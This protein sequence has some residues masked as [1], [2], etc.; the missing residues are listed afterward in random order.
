MA[1]PLQAWPYSFASCFTPSRRDS[2][3]CVSS[4]NV[5]GANYRKPVCMCAPYLYFVS[6]G[7]GT[8]RCNFSQ[9]CEQLQS[10]YP[11]IPYCKGKGLLKNSDMNVYIIPH[12]LT[13]VIILRSPFRNH[14]TVNPCKLCYS[15]IH[16]TFPSALYTCTSVDLSRMV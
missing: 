5:K 4:N 1:S 13:I 3:S 14:L 6:V 2:S 15:S 7:I 11:D 10:V 12:V 9:L 8:L 16:P